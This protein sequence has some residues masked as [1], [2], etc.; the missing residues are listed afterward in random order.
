MNVLM[1]LSNPVKN[2]TRVLYEIDALKKEGHS[3]KIIVWDK[4]KNLS[5]R[6]VWKDFEIFRL[7]TF[8]LDK[9]WNVLDYPIWW[10]SS[11]KKALLLYKKDFQF[12]VVHCH[13]LDTLPTGFILKKLLGCKLIYDAHEIWKLMFEKKVP[14]IYTSFFDKLERKL[15]GY[16][17][18]MIVIDEAYKNYY[19]KFTNKNI[20]IV[21]HCKPLKYSEYKPPNNKV[22]TLCYIGSRGKKRFFPDIID[23]VEEIDNVKLV[24]A[25]KEKDKN[26]EKKIKKQMEKYKCVD[27]LGEIP[28]ED[29]LPLTRNSDATFILVN[30]E[31]DEHYKYNV[32]NKQFE[33][34]VCGRPII[35][36]ENTYSGNITKEKECGL[37]VTYKR[38]K[39]KKAIILLRDNKELCKKLGKN[40]FEAAFK[41]YNWPKEKEKLIDVY[42]KIEKNL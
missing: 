36:T 31:E 17:D 7:H 37:V 11:L 41:E 1:L 6:E 24:L 19:Q 14:R 27:Y 33:A 16:I 3:V 42:K 28:T 10:K 8:I 5:K 34:M 29:I 9:F 23:L 32:F 12:D 21:T 35:C 18:E 20:T 22:F 15:L 13:D 4:Y 30:V 40:A 2:D 38:E 39:I 26:A 25:G